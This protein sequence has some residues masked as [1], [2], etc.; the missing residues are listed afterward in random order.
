MDRT[1]KNNSNSCE[2]ANNLATN[3]ASSTTTTANNSTTTPWSNNK[4]SPPNEEDS[5]E[6]DTDNAATPAKVT[7]PLAPKFTNNEVS[8]RFLL[9]REDLNEPRNCVFN[10]VELNLN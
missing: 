10:K 7:D 1:K 4:E 3:N 8:F 5:N 9:L 2:F 6:D